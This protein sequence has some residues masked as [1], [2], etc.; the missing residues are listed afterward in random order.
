VKIRLEHGIPIA[1]ARGLPCPDEEGHGLKCR[2][3]EQLEEGG[4]PRVV[5]ESA[6]IGREAAKSLV[7][8]CLRHVITWNSIIIIHRTA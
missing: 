5:S 3:V 6:V 8:K 7:Y 1:M 4:Y 2:E